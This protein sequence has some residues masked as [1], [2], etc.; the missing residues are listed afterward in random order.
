M[1]KLRQRN[2]RQEGWVELDKSTKPHSWKARWLDWSQVRVDEHGRLRPKQRS[3]LLGRKAQGGFLTK[4]AAETEWAKVRAKHMA[5]SVATLDGELSFF[6][7][8]TKVFQPARTAVRPWCRGTLDKFTYF[9]GL[10]ELSFGAK[11]LST[12]TSAEIQKHVVDLARRYCQ[13]TTLGSLMYIRAIFSHAV[14]SETIARNPAKLVRTPETRP[15]RQPYISLEQVQLLEAKLSGRDLVILRLFTRTGLRAGEVFALQFRDLRPDRTLFIQRSVTKGVV[16]PPKTEESRNAVA[17]PATLHQELL[18]LKATAKDASP[19]AWIFPATR[20]RGSKVMPM[21]SANWLK[22]VLKPVAAK[23]GFQITLHAF[24][25]GFATIANARGGNT[26]NIQEQLR[27]RHMSTTTDMYMKAVP[28]GTR[29]LV[30]DLDQAMRAG[31]A[32]TA[33]NGS[34]PL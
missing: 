4:S 10:T 3:L 34:N 13:D 5:G 30:E 11:H 24:R 29:L 23:M 25:R 7:Y 18:D 28:E 31:D 20:K 12:I 21:S 17:I 2:R 8:A 6:D 15:R 27:H 1:P 14:D 9:M 22:R 32:P 19:D 33:S 26:K 16:G